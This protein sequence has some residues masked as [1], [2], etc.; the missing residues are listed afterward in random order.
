MAMTSNERDG[1]KNLN[2][3]CKKSEC[4]ISSYSQ[5]NMYEDFAETFMAY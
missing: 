4:F 3:S 2:S 5:K 1:W